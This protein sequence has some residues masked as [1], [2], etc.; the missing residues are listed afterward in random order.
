MVSV[1]LTEEEIRKKRIKYKKKFAET[2]SW[3]NPRRIGLKNSGYKILVDRKNKI[4]GAHIFY[5]N[6]DEIINLFLFAMKNNMKS[7]EMKDYL[8]AYPS[9]SYDIKYMI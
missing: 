3:Y 4:L 2:S 1:G 6:S 7:E 5:P 9:S 8:M